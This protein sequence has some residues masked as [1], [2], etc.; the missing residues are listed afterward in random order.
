MCQRNSWGGNLIHKRSTITDLIMDNLSRVYRGSGEKL[1]S[2]LGE[3]A[4][5]ATV[6]RLKAELTN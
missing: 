5:S 3:T 2:G 4:C 6:V 1:N